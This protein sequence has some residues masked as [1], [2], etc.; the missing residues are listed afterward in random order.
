MGGHSTAG[1]AELGTP[2]KDRQLA[3]PRAYTGMT[4]QAEQGRAGHICL[5]Q[6]LLLPSSG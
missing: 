1:Q 4:R 2:C 3:G 6:W 5:V